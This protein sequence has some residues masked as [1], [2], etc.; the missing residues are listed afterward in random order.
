MS[1]IE[2]LQ[3][4]DNKKAYDLCQKLSR[5]SSESNK[6]YAYFNDFISLLGSKNA[7]VRTRGFILA[8]AQAQWDSDNLLAKN[9]DT[10]LKIIYDEKPIVVR[11]G[12]A[13][14]PEVILYHPEFSQKIN[15]YL[16]QIDLT[17]YPE[18]MRP[19]IKKDIQELKKSLNI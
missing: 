3:D 7:Y 1:I 13:A 15:D 18:S 5:E 14:L 11:K 10:L 12:L 19:L 16:K 2:Q 9:L 17:K 8:C 4:K 6:Y